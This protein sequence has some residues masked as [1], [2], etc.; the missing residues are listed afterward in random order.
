MGFLCV[1]VCVLSYILKMICG[2]T[3]CDM[4]KP[5]IQINVVL[6]LQ[7]AWIFREKEAAVHSQHF[8]KWVL[9]NKQNRKCTIKLNLI[10]NDN[11]TYTIS[12]QAFM[13]LY[14]KSI[15]T[16]WYNLWDFT[17]IPNTKLHPLNLIGKAKQRRWPEPEL[18]R[19]NPS[20]KPWL[21]PNSTSKTGRE[22]S[23]PF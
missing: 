16:H 21:L 19:N 13:Q 18:K 1:C 22:H 11:A 4:R 10:C 14:T 7:L 17:Q 20:S 5:L 15:W 23:H 8:L 9:K 2:D 6:L 3:V 12:V